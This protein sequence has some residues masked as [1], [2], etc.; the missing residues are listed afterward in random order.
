MLT[1]RRLEHLTRATASRAHLSRRFEVQIPGAA[2]HRQ[3][4]HSKYDHAED[5]GE[6]NTTPCRG[7]QDELFARHAVTLSPAGGTGNKV[8]GLLNISHCDE[9]D[10]QLAFVISSSLKRRH[11]SEGQWTMGAARIATHLNSELL[12]GPRPRMANGL[13]RS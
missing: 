5:Q 3:P 12:Q 8:E 7:C 2:A 6:D 13:L 9:M 4:S 1:P 10:D 11:L